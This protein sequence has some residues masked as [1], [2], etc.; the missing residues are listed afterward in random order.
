M[1]FNFPMPQVIP[2]N[3]LRIL[4]TATKPLASNGKFYSTVDAAVD[5]LTSGGW[6]YVPIGTWNLVTLSNDKVLLFG[7]GWGTII[8]GGTTGHAINITG[9]DC[10]I[11]DLQVK[12]DVGQAN[13][14]DGV[15]AAGTHTRIINVFVN[16]ADRFALNLVGA[17]CIAH[18]CRLYD[19]D[20]YGLGV[21]GVDTQLSQIWINQAGS[22]GAIIANQR[23]LL[24]NFGIYN[25]VTFGV[26]ITSAGDNSE[27]NGGIINIS[28]NDGL[29]IHANAEDCIA[30]SLRITAWTN[31]AVDD[32]SGTSTIGDIE[33]T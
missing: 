17:N 5:A 30:D 18:L 31:E 25:S 26:Y 24:S 15:R 23:C 14:Y 21:Y 28:G 20:E 3:R 4:S 2:N 11:R 33:T 10:I 12:T 27:L 9:D 7:A 22:G 19:A 6:V 16:G 1:S 32:N 8:D 29:Y 13:D